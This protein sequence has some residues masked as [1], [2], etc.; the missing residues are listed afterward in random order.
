MNYTLV[1]LD[2]TQSAQQFAQSTID[3]ANGTTLIFFGTDTK[4]QELEI[5]GVPG[6]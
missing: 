6:E 4:V 3:L 2:T 1:V 5:E